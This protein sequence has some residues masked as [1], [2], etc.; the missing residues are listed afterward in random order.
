MEAGDL[1]LKGF[2][3]LRNHFETQAGVQIQSPCAE[4]GGHRGAEKARVGNVRER[5]TLCSW[6]ASSSRP[7]S[8]S[9]G[10]RAR[11]DGA[12]QDLRVLTGKLKN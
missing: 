2:F 11:R 7:P 6:A 5:V 1:S 9:E 4:R 3:E 10:C 12:G 8:Q